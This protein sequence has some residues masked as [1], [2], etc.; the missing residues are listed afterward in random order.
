[1]RV[2]M[3]LDTPHT[4]HHTAA[5]WVTGNPHAVVTTHAMPATISALTRVLRAGEL[6][7]A[8]P[9][10]WIPITRHDTSTDWT[11]SAA[12]LATACGVTS[13]LP[14]GPTNPHHTAVLAVDHA[15]TAA[16]GWGVWAHLSREL[17]GTNLPA[18]RT[19][20]PAHAATA[21]ATSIH[22]ARDLLRHADLHVVWDQPTPLTG[23]HGLGAV[24]ALDGHEDP[25]TAQ[26]NERFLTELISH[27]PHTDPQRSLTPTPSAKDL[28]RV[29][30]AGT[31]GGLTWLL[32]LSGVRHSHLTPYLANALNAETIC[33]S[34][35]LIVAVQPTLDART[36]ATTPAGIAAQ[37][38]APH[39][40]PVVVVATDIIMGRRERAQHGIAGAYPSTT[41]TY[42]DTLQRVARTWHEV[43]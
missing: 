30:G 34:S 9:I 29:E 7:D 1:M 28:A 39:A 37:A 15:M 23:F 40:I 11:F 25:H 22:A 2:T 6:A 33:A 17:T 32:S 42:N 43:L 24:N 27:Y 4:P 3:L 19:Q 31:G 10:T 5:Q 21:L 35:D 13:L 18:W 41:A 12:A 38:A 14:H 16:H 26:D 36:I 20:P 8:T